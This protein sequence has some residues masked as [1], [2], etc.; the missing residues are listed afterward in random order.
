MSSDSSRN[1]LSASNSFTDAPL[2]ALFARTAMPAIFVMSMNGLLSVVDALFL[3]LYVGAD[4][5][6]AVT[7]MFPIQMLI[8]AL[9]TLVSSGMS[10]LLARHLGAKR[11]NEAQALF[12]GAHGLALLISLLFIAAFLIWGETITLTLAGGSPRLAALGIVYLRIMAFTSPLFFMLSL[13][14]DGLRNEGQAALMAAISLFVSLANIALNYLFIALLNMGVA[15]SA[16]GTALAQALAFVIVMIYR[17]RGRTVLKPSCLWQHAPFTAWRQMLALGAPQSLNF[18]G[19]A[20]VST[21]IIASLQ[22]TR[23]PH[24]AE[25]ITA[26]GIITRILTFAFLPL[27]GL[28]L[29][30]QSIIGN[31]F[32]AAHWHR[33][34]AGLRIG[35]MLSLSYC[36]LIEVLLIG[37][38]API[39][40]LFVDDAQI[41]AEVVRIIPI[42]TAMYF[43]S[44]PL[45]I[46][47]SY[48]QAI[49]DAPNAAILGLSKAYL[50]L[51]PMIF[52]LPLRF[53][54]TGIWLASPLAEIMLLTSAVLVLAGTA[55]SRGHK[56]G[57]FISHEETNP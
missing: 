39:G 18:L 4:A 16:Y 42:M 47:S 30:F 48:F 55:R 12:A 23:T 41:V 20:L 13:H 46:T 14:S 33:S 26:Y 1:N 51:L 25:T 7:L 36:L 19:M 5:L 15:G 29:A 24:Y 17:Q 3:G 53:G 52:L 57:L 44:G 56:W 27:M 50:F 2:G 32:G 54:E 8:I 9:T 34:N 31:N 22:M 38:A 6:A 28:A 21:A 45:L 11:I 10:S 43:L 40:A 49:G 35:L 37:F